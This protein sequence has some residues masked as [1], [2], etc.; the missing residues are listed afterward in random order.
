MNGLNAWLGSAWE[1][2]Q[3]V[4]GPVEKDV[5]LW[6]LLAAGGLAV[7]IMLRVMATATSNQ[8]GGVFS[9]TVLLLVGTLLVLL[10]AVAG[11]RWGVGDT[12]PEGFVRWVPMISAVAAMLILVV[13]FMCLLQRVKYLTGLI[14]IVVSVAVGVLV[15][16]GIRAIFQGVKGGERVGEIIEG[17]MDY[18]DVQ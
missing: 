14:S 3:R 10:A 7:W 4:L 17:R 1:M 8:N 13:P 5:Y 18:R 12:D 9:N 11:Q 16:I 6:I 15:V 2:L